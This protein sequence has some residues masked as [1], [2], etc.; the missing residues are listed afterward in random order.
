MRKNEYGSV[1][2]RK[3]LS[4]EQVDMTPM[5]DVTFLLLIFFMVT[6]AF[7]MQKS[8]EMP[9]Q[10]TEVPSRSQVD[11]PPDQ[12]R[13]VEVQID[14]SGGFLVMAHEWQRETMGKQS[15]V[16]ALKD[17]IATESSDDRLLV[18]VHELARLHAL[19]DALDAGTIAGY[20]TLEITQ[21]AEFN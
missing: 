7:S 12:P 10:R 19:V 14:K 16:A 1:P 4:E 18:K 2:A 9:H 11:P 21:I 17:S 3:H 13:A 20:T 15:L 5:V 6:A 8:I